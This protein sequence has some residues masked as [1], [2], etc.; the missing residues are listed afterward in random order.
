MR[1]GLCARVVRVGVVVSVLPGAA[2][3]RI[4]FERTGA[5]VVGVVFLGVG[6]G[7]DRVVGWL[8]V[9]NCTVDASILFF[10]V[11]LVCVVCG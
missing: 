11:R 7:A 4:P 1:A 3:S 6:C 9:E 10:V 5:C 8:L 2:W